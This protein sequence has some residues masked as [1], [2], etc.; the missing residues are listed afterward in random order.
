M[1][2]AEE[3][4]AS[5]LPDDQ[6]KLQVS[7]CPLVL[8]AAYRNLE[9]YQH[10]LPFLPLLSQLTDDWRSWELTDVGM[11]VL[12]L[13]MYSKVLIFQE[14]KLSELLGIPLSEDVAVRVPQHK[15]WVRLLSKQLT[16]SDMEK[17]VK[18]FRCSPEEDRYFAFLGPGNK[19]PDGWIILEEFVSGELWIV[20]FESKKRSTDQ[21]LPSNEV[22]QR[23]FDKRYSVGGVKHIMLYVSDQRQPKRGAEREAPDDMCIVDAAKQ[24]AFYSTSWC[25]IKQQLSY[26]SQ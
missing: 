26:A 2:S 8:L 20:H 25:L 6:V 10:G 1:S 4:E 19:G 18:E 24:E 22:L 9:V 17:L 5:A 15:L 23:E 14:V 7:L 16:D 21:V 3:Q 12:R 13:L 11:I